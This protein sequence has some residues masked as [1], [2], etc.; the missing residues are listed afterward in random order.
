MPAPTSRSPRWRASL[1]LGL[2]VLLSGCLKYDLTL[3]VNEDDTLDGTLIVAVAREFAVGEDIFGQSGEL[4][5]SEGSVTKEPYED[6]DYL[7]SRY[8]ITGVPISEIDALSTDRSTRFSLTREGE[9]Y[10]LDATVNFNV[11][12]TETVP[13]EAS[14]SALVS[15]TFPGAVLESNGT[16]DGNSV[17]W[18]QLRPDADNTLT[19]RASAIGNGQASSAT[20]SGTPWWIWVLGGAGALLVL[21]VLGTVLFRRR[22][23]GNAAQAAAAQGGLPAHQQGG[24]DDYGNW[25]AAPAY[26]QQSGYYGSGQ[27]GGYDS[28]YGAYGGTYGDQY[29]AYRDTNSGDNSGSYWDTYRGPPGTE[30]LPQVWNPQTGYGYSPHPQD[31][32]GQPSGG[33]SEQTLVNQPTTPQPPNAW[34]QGRPV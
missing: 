11:A 7:G 30:P 5:P 20:D 1:L 17:T 9:E 2:A 25:V 16:I 13:M 22:R 33:Y 15:F 19:A 24:Y 6:A 10:L 21:G 12:G 34:R 31:S 28:Y 18:T 29:G 14:F 8:V 4:T 3:V 32:Y 23:A 27:E 26:G